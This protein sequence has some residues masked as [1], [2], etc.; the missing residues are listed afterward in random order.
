MQA[1]TSQPYKDLTWTG[2][3]KRPLYTNIWLEWQLLTMTLFPCPEGVTVSGDLCT[4]FL[5]RPPWQRPRWARS[6]GRASVAR[7][8][9]SKPSVQSAVCSSLTS[10][11]NL[12]QIWRI[13][14]PHNWFV[15]TIFTQLV[16]EMPQSSVQRHWAQL[17]QRIS[18]QL[19]L[20]L[21]L[22]LHFPGILAYYDIAVAG[23]EGLK[24]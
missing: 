13:F 9:C 4:A 7:P 2:T 11:E 21:N 5:N 10:W 20:P 15:T 19:R 12:L 18:R 3:T 1:L 23:G 22:H 16:N 24:G 17:V 6:C 14:G 8:V